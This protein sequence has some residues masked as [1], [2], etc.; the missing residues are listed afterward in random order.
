MN[1]LMYYR[2]SLT[3]YNQNNKAFKFLG[4]DYY[5]FLHFKLSIYKPDKSRIPAIAIEIILFG[6]CVNFLSHRKL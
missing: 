1:Y 4:V 5:R 6:L 2:P 3:F